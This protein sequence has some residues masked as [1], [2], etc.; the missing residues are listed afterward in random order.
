MRPLLALAIVI[1]AAVPAHAEGPDEQPLAIAVNP[2]FRWPGADAV[3]ASGY[4]RLTEHQVLRINAS[5][6]DFN[7]NPAGDLIAILAGGDGDEASHSGRVTDVGAGWMYFPRRRWSGITF[8]LGILR[9]ARA[10]R[11]E[12]EFAADEIVETD[13]DTWAGRGLVGWSWLI[14][15]RIMI[16]V[17]GGVSVGYEL[18]HEIVTPS[19]FDPMPTRRGVRR[20][21]VAGEAFMR[22]GVAFG[23]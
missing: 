13:T 22:I 11:V 20:T 7:G 18:G 21:D 6:Y 3:A 9:R 5:S 4:A 23:M 16:S 12:D 1:A 2:P 10:I 8:E 17:A 19:S 15:H 14:D